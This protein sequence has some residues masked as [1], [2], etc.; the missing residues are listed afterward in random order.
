MR[1]PN[2]A[3][4]GQ[5]PAQ[6]RGMPFHLAVGVGRDRE[7]LR[8]QYDHLSNPELSR[9]ATTAAAGA[10]ELR[11]LLRGI[12]SFIVLTIAL[13][14]HALQN[15]RSDRLVTTRINGRYPKSVRTR[16]RK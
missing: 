12:C 15:V 4:A 1:K 14:V 6:Q 16:G 11:A 9:L 8:Q 5:A 2:P 7:K 3:K 13:V 10:A